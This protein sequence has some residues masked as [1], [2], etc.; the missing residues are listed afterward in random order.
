MI[1]ETENIQIN[2]IKYLTELKYS[3]LENYKNI[4]NLIKYHIIYKNN[5]QKKIIFKIKIEELSDNNNNLVDEINIYIKKFIKI[6]KIN[7]EFNKFISEDDYKNNNKLYFINNFE[8][9]ENFQY[10]IFTDSILGLNIIKESLKQN[11][12]IN[13]K[14]IYLINNQTD[15]N[16]LEIIKNENNENDFILRIIIEITEPLINL[17]IKFF[18]YL[19]IN[20]EENYYILN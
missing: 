4:N 13:K 17:Y 18:N 9:K 1:T 5:N 15:N 10:L 14:I 6:T 20:N 12:N 3:F 16:K 2:N 8:L 19:F 7:S 11:E